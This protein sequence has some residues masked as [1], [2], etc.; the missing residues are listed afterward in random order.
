MNSKRY[1]NDTQLLDLMGGNDLEALKTLVN[2]YWQPLYRFALQH[3]SD[4]KK[5]ASLVTGLFNKLWDSRNAIPEQFCLQSYLSVQLRIALKSTA[6][7]PPVNMATDMQ[8]N[9]DADHFPA[10]GMNFRKMVMVL[11]Q[12]FAA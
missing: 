12:K 9:F 3:Y 1:L 6:D 2:R 10:E 7:M 8:K 5:S 11:R 4:S